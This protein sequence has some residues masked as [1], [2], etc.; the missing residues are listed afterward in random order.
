[1]H[2]NITNYTIKPSCNSRKSRMENRCCKFFFGNS[3]KSYYEEIKRAI[4]IGK[5]EKVEQEFYPKFMVERAEKVLKQCE[6]SCSIF[7]SNIQ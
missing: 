5:E 2:L 4:A 6:S 7:S 1:M 3:T